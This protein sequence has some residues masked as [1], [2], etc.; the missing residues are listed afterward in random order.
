MV[1][2]LFLTAQVALLSAT[3]HSSEPSEVTIS[4]DT[5]AAVWII[6]VKNYGLQPLSY[7]RINEFPRSLGI[8]FWLQGEGREIWA[9]NNAELLGVFGNPADIRNIAPD[10]SVVFKLDPR[11]VSAE[12]PETVKLWLQG[13][14]YQIYDMRIVFRD[15]AS[16]RIWNDGPEIV[17]P[18]R[19]EQTEALKP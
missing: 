15:F 1:S 3:G 2:T 6:T 14:E 11:N 8:E 9:G 4:V 19:G 10:E 5:T 16:R 18:K 12:D 17:D 13:I 7:E